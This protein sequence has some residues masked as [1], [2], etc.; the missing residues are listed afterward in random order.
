MLQRKA[1]KGERDREMLASLNDIPY[2]T[3][4]MEIEREE[5]P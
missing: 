5:N 1:C 2:S 3:R 4:A